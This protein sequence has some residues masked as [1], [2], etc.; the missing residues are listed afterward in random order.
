MS[1]CLFLVKVMDGCEVELVRLCCGW[2]GKLLFWMMIVVWLVLG[3]RV[4][5]LVWLRV[6]LKNLECL[7]I[8]LL[9]RL[10]VMNLGLFLLL[11]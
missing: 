11:V 9:S 4:L 1:L 8:L 5:L 3:S 7:V 10:M 2:W 6:M